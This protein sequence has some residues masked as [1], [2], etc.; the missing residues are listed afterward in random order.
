MVPGPM[1][2]PSITIDLEERN[3]LHRF[4]VHY[5]EA[6]ETLDDPERAGVGL[7]VLVAL[8]QAADGDHGTYQLP[9]SAEIRDFLIEVR[10]TEWKTLDSGEG[11]DR[12]Q[13]ADLLATVS[14]LLLEFQGAPA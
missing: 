3:L 13:S 8:G 14:R 2:P 4:T 12:E 11:A 5:E 7:A 10:D 9:L 6:I 1:R